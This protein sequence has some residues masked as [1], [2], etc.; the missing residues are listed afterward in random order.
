MEQIVFAAEQPPCRSA[1]PLNTSVRRRR[2]G[3]DLSK[4]PNA[5]L[6][7]FKNNRFVEY[8]EPDYTF[9]EPEVPLASLPEAGGP[10]AFDIVMMVLD[11]LTLAGVAAVIVLQVK[12]RGK[13]E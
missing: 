3:E 1:P 5:V 13:E 12:K 4:N 10:G 2:T 9:E 7:R 11:V 8:V 6:N